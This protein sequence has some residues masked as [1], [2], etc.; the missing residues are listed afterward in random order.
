MQRR[1]SDARDALYGACL[2]RSRC[3]CCHARSVRCY[4]TSERR[5]D[6][7]AAYAVSLCLRCYDCHAL[8]PSPDAMPLDAC[9]SATSIFASLRRAAAAAYVAAFADAMLR[10]ASRCRQIIEYQT[11]RC[12]AARA[13][14][15]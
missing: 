13:L 1:A 15:L 12:R 9:H 2:A 5:Y 7:D 10:H 8:I 4:A 3:R 14:S 11:P 6:A